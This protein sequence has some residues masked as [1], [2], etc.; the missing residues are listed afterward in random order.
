MHKKLGL[1]L[2]HFLKKIYVINYQ[3]LWAFSTIHAI[4]L[5]GILNYYAASD[6]FLTPA[7]RVQAK[8]PIKVYFILRAYWVWN[9]HKVLVGSLVKIFSA[10]SLDFLNNILLIV[11]RKIPAKNVQNWSEFLESSFFYFTTAKRAKS[12]NSLM[13]I[14]DKMSWRR[15]RWSL[16][17]KDRYLL[18]SEPEEDLTRHCLCAWGLKGLCEQR[19]FTSSFLTLW[20]LSDLWKAEGWRPMKL[21]VRRFWGFKANCFCFL[22]TLPSNS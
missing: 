4:L 10:L 6:F 11:S 20:F 14:Q 9:T 13:N 8:H 2:P 18:K 17:M 3:N 21:K 22:K 7:S 1:H 15:V 16:N 12:Y 19:V 5:H